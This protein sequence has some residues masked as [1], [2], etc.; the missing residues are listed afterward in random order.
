M[1]MCKKDDTQKNS[2][3][4][5]AKEYIYHQAFDPREALKVPHKK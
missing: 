1:T 3:L 2:F 5:K 4:L